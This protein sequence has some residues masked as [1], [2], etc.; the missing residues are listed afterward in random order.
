ME[1]KA[2]VFPVLIALL[3]VLAAC[4]N[5]VGARKSSQDIESAIKENLSIDE[6]TGLEY[7]LV[8][9]D[10]GELSITFS[11]EE[12]ILQSNFLS[13]CQEISDI[14]SP[15]VSD[16]GWTFRELEFTLSQG[17]ELLLTLDTTDFTTFD[18]FN[19]KSYEKEKGVTIEDLTKVIG[20]TI[21]YDDFMDRYI[22]ISNVAS[23]APNSAGGVDVEITWH[24]SDT[25]LSDVKYIW[26]TMV[27][28][29]AVGD[30][31]QSEIGG[32][33]LF[34]GKL[35]GPISDKKSY[36]T[37]WENAWYNNTIVKVEITKIEVEFMD[38]TRVIGE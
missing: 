6:T 1:K 32:K 36:V 18:Y 12:P 35:T 23:S 31:Q 5:G 9:V 25:I 16:S 24:R 20:T 2:K 3:M 11:L 8:T 38:G 29:N 21:P 22:S 26:F 30:V 17:D 10:E 28:Y 13:Q 14:V 15:I 27:P 33:S 34:I 37:T 19:L 7:L 4:G